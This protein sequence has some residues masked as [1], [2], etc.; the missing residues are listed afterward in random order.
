[1]LGDFVGGYFG[2]FFALVSVL[3]LIRTIKDQ[4]QADRREKFENKYFELVKMHRD[5]VA[6]LELRKSKGRRVFVLMLRELRGILDIVRDLSDTHEKNLT[7][8]Q[9]LHVAYY[10]LF[11]GTGP[12][13]SRMLTNVLGEFDPTFVSM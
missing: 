12:Q 10:C 2:S 13:S 9:L 5:N 6:E 4:R 3:L 8:R 7:P 1:Q 11:F